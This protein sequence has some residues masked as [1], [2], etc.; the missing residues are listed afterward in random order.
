MA[1]AE[2]GTLLLAIQRLHLRIM[3]IRL[4][5]RSQLKLYRHLSNTLLQVPIQQRQQWQQRQ[6]PS[7]Q[8]QLQQ[9]R[10]HPLRHPPPPLPLLPQSKWGPICRFHES[11]WTARSAN[12]DSKRE[13]YLRS[14]GWCF[15][16]VSFCV[17]FHFLKAQ[18]VGYQ[19][20]SVA[21]Y[22]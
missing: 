9:T 11:V 19:S 7:K 4:L 1:V 18:F 16:T 10:F 12:C 5:P 13:L 20:V 3:R 22:S 17:H 15:F 8:Q 6:T 2:C 14:G 21:R